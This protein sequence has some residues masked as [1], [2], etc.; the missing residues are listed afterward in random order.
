M[1]SGSYAARALLLPPVWAAAAFR[2]QL[3]CVV[4]LLWSVLN[5]LLG[6]VLLLETP[7]CEEGMV[8]GCDHQYV[9][10]VSID[11]NLPSL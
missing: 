1:S 2:S 9:K 8:D 7:V 4:F 5:A 3:R 11:A 6:V 10:V